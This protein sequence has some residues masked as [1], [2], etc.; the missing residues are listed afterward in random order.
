M[1]EADEGEK[2]S[3][4]AHVEER[5]EG[6][7][8]KKTEGRKEKKKKERS[9]EGERRILSRR[10]GCMQGLE[11]EWTLAGAPGAQKAVGRGLGPSVRISGIA[12]PVYG[13]LHWDTLLP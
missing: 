13:T 2:M 12:T 1:M 6:R 11:I 9:L 7:E 10:P 8:R 5:D 4:E 3:P